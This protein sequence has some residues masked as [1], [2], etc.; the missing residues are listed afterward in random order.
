MA[1]GRIILCA[2]IG[3]SSLKAGLISTQGEGISFVRRA[4]PAEAAAAGTV[5]TGHWEAAF[6]SAVCRLF[7]E[8][9]GLIPSAL[10][11]SGNGPTFI[12][13]TAKGEV[14]TPLY[15]YGAG[16]PIPGGA[17]PD[18]LPSLFLPHAAA[19]MRNRPAEYEASRYLFS[20]QEWFSYRLGADPVTILPSPAYEKYYWDDEQCRLYGLDREKFPV[21]AE[22]GSPIGTVSSEAARSFGLPE[23]LP[24][25]GG[26]PDFIMALIGAGA[27]EEGLVC[28]RAGSSEGI[29]VCARVPA[30]SGE[31]RSLPHIRE[32]FW[33]VSAMIPS[34]GRLFEWF[35]VITGQDGR[36]YESLMEEISAVSG[37]APVPSASSFGGFRSFMGE[38]VFYPD[39]SC[40]GKYT[41]PSVFIS[42]A[43]LTS[44]AELGRAVVEAIAYSV[45][46]AL[47]TLEEN[48]FP[49]REMRISGGQAKSHVWNQWKA[50]ITG[51]VLHI[52]EISDG[53]LAGGACLAMTAMKEA[54]DLRDACR[55]A[56][57][58][59]K[60]YFPNE[61]RNEFY[62][63]RFGEYRDFC[64]K[65][66]AFFA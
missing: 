52:P 57:H 10:C 64:A 51:C 19:F 23:G 63:R 24:I 61:D 34:S 20:S 28:D 14:L 29:N 44:R 60:T 47:Q 7:T 43:G 40:S 36:D 9:P 6:K 15:W 16:A 38:G 18:S 62:S 22:L 65:L 46:G 4:Y 37:S 42:A 45:K 59:G 41:A 56:V 49:V 66:G 8:N 25:I 33:N 2:D 3:T 5:N 50:D 32:G 39:I 30:E 1:P 27:I 35:R 31:L 11:I 53:E 58:I 12:P 13:I 48:G 55:K 21:F 54:S 17:G 26:G